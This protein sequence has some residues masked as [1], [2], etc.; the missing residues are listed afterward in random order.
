MV[1]VAAPVEVKVTTWV[2]PTLSATFPK[3]RLGVLVLRIGN[4]AFSWSA[5]FSVAAPAFAV[6]L[7]VCAVGTPDTFNVNWPEVPFAATITAGGAITAALLL[8]RATLK[9]PAGA[10]WP[11][12]TVQTSVPV[13]VMDALLQEKPVSCGIPVP[14]SATTAVLFVEELLVTVNWPVAAPSAEGVNCTLSVADLPAF[15]VSGKV[16]EMRVNPAPVTV[17]PL[18]VTG[19]VPVEFRFTDWAA[20]AFTATLPKDTLVA[21]TLSVGTGAFCT[22]AKVSVTVPSLAV[23]VTACGVETTDPVAVK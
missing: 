15:T 11:I 14:F 6:R 5:K 20:S 22:R 18:M 9:A 8:D 4:A 23:T 17:A 3:A 16:P 19:P 12:V 13:P 2:A 1:T 7:A 10:G 21:L